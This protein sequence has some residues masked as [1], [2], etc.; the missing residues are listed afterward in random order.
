MK[1]VLVV[2]DDTAMRE[3]LDEQLRRRGFEVTSAASGAEA[4]ERFAAKDFDAVLTD[5]NMKG[6][7]GV[8]LCRKLLDKRPEVPVLVLTAFGSLDAAMQ[9]IRAG[10]YDFITKP[11]EMEPLAVALNRALENLALKREVR[12]L[13]D[14]AR[15]DEA[16]DLTG[17][18][19]AIRRV[20]ELIAR[21]ADSEAS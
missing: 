9:A 18:S 5:L 14:G 1:P 21:V 11:V 2:E 15:G 8:E 10:A 7:N 17:S 20:R 19:E 4:L 6:M 13:R 3:L 12:R 16:R